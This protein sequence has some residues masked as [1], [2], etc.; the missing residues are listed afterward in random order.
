MRL[1]LVLGSVLAGTVI[2]VVVI[3]SVF[4]AEDVEHVFKSETTE[5]RAPHGEWVRSVPGRRAEV[6]AV[7]DSKAP[8]DR[9]VAALIER[10][11]PD[12]VLYV[13]DV[14][15]SGTRDDFEAWDAVWGDLT[16]RMAP[17]PGNHDWPESAEGYDPYWTDVRGTPPP[18]HYAFEA[19]GWQILALNSEHDEQEAQASWARARTASR[20]CTIAFWH[21]PRWS[22]GPH[23]DNEATDALWRAVRGRA[24]AVISGHEHNMQ[25][26]EP[27]NRT[28][29]FISG[30]GGSSHTVPD[31]DDRRLDFGDGI[32]YGALRLV[33]TPASA[34]WA[35][36]AT[37]ARI[38]DSGVL[39]CRR[40][41]ND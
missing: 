39:R 26:L 23:G 36:V 16:R 29:Q 18:T 20:N 33:L 24:A 13:G 31:K 4:G 8:D 1:L 12:R 38:L 27:L 41:D 37:D 32:H 11:A 30:A 21:R 3:V 15:T 35:F 17:T 9:P 6:W 25:R 5:Y 40:D 2:I 34:R 28:I 10:A 14:Y 19:G 7:G 22:A